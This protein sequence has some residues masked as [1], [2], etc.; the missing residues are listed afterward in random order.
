M[1][2]VGLLGNKGCGKDTLA[3]YLVKD[4]EFIKYNFAAVSYIHL[5]LPTK[6]I[7]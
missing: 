6:R 4:K 5:T 2:R 7:V 3:D 1:D